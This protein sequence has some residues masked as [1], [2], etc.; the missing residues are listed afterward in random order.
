MAIAG[1]LLIL[2]GPLVGYLY[3]RFRF[4]QK[5]DSLSARQRRLHTKGVDITPP[6]VEKS[7]S[8]GETPGIEDTLQLLREDIEQ[9]SLELSIVRQDYEIEIK[10]LRDE[11]ASLRDEISK[12]RGTP[13]EVRDI[14]PESPHVVEVTEY[15]STLT[16]ESEEV[17]DVIEPQ[18]DAYAYLYPDASEST[19]IYDLDIVEEIGEPETDDTVV[20]PEEMKDTNSGTEDEKPPATKDANREAPSVR[21][22]R[23]PKLKETRGQKL[24]NEPRHGPVPLPTFTP[25]FELLGGKIENGRDRSAVRGVVRLSDDQFEVLTDL[26]YATLDKI[27]CLSSSEVHRLADIFKLQTSVIETD[28]IPNAQLQLFERDD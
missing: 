15:Y 6:L 10:V 25:V 18:A 3:Y 12:L 26:G 14:V 1:A 4:K 11:N 20:E 19:D 28:W 7:S 24:E 8:H 9:K 23:P 16:P 27:A 5:I 2:G 13:V 22:D 17:E 21:F